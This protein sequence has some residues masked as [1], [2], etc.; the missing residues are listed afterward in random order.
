MSFVL[1]QKRL[2]PAA[3]SAR[4]DFHCNAL[5]I[6][7]NIPFLERFF[8]V[9]ATWFGKPKQNNWSVEKATYHWGDGRFAFITPCRVVHYSLWPT[10]NEAEKCKAKVDRTGCG[11]ECR[12]WTHYIVDLDEAK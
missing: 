12:P 11:G 7:R 5:S 3:F 6:Q 1:E 4:Q 9:F 8:E 2:C 10:R